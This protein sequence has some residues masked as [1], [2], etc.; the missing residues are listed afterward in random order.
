MLIKTFTLKKILKR[1]HNKHEAKFLRLTNSKWS[2]VKYLINLI[3]L[4]CVFIKS[5]D[6][7]KYFIIHQVFDIYDKL[8]NHLDQARSKLSRK[9][10]IWKKIMLKDLIATKVKLRQ[11]YTKIQDSLNHLYE[12]TT[13]LS[14]NRKNAIFQDSNWKI[15]NDKTF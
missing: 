14:S 8:F 2:Q 3:K 6:Q 5:I 7:F 10:M 15:S 1:Y 9:K 12:K 4:F 13:L 11:Y